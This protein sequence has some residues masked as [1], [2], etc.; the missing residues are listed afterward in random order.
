M[1]TDEKVTNAPAATSAGTAP[2]VTERTPSPIA[3]TVDA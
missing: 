3:P 1:M 2:F